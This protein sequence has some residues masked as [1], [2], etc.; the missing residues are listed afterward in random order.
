MQL[1]YCDKKGSNTGSCPCI[2]TFKGN[3]VDEKGKIFLSH[4]CLEH[5]YCGTVHKSI[6][7]ESMLV[8]DQSKALVEVNSF[9][10]TYI[11]KEVFSKF[12]RNKHAL[13][14]VY[15]KDNGSIMC[16]NPKNKEWKLVYYHQIIQ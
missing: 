4:R 11:G 9:L 5:R 12:H 2:A 16:Q 8:L 10:R 15:L 6:D 7:K 3:L 13:I 1:I 14:G